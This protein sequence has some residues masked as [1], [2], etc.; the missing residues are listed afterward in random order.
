MRTMR[1]ASL[2]GVWLLAF[3]LSLGSQEQKPPTAP[4]MSKN[5]T[6][7][8][9][10]TRWFGCQEYQ[11]RSAAEAMPEEKW[12]YRPAAGLFKNEKPPFGPVELRTFAEQVK[13]V[14]CS[15][16]AFAAELDGAKPPEAC[17]NGGP[18][19]A[20]TRKELLARGGPLWPG[21][22]LS[23]RKQHCATGKP[24]QSSRIE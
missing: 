13:H 12:S 3:G 20:R 11:F 14:A 23:A 21:G 1:K 22:Y 18:N 15:N 10:F 8:K 7:G 17:D 9:A 2:L 24:A 5:E 19:P 6:P 16:F 4:E